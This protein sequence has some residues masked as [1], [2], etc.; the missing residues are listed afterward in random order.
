MFPDKRIQL[1]EV[2]P[3]S[4]EVTYYCKPTAAGNGDGLSWAN[5]C[6]FRTAVSRCSGTKLTTI[7]LGAGIH[8]TDNGSDATGTT[9]SA[10][11]VRVVGFGD[12]EEI[13]Q[14]SQLANQ[15]ASAT[16]VLKVTGN[17]FSLSHVAFDNSAELDKIVTHLNLQ[18]NYSTVRYCV[19]RQGTGDGACTGILI[20]NSS[21]SHTIE[22]NRFRRLEGNGINFGAASRFYINSN[23]F[24]SCAT[25]V[26]ASSAN[27]DSG[28]FRDNKYLNCTTALNI[29]T[30]VGKTWYFINAFYGNNTTNFTDVAS[31]GGTI[32]ILNPV[33]S[34]MAKNTYPTGAGITVAK[35]ANAWVWGAYVDI[36]PA[37]TLAKPFKLDMLNVQSWNAAQVFKI[38]LFY[39]AA[40]PGTISLGVHELLLGDP[41]AN[42]RVYAPL[43]LDVFVPAYATV[44]AKIMSS[45][46][47]SDN[48]VVTLGYD[49]L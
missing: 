47:S 38:E 46:A 31:Y 23:V 12:D 8:N 40:S 35:D 32:N 10:N 19:F 34:G 45:T 41:A 18:G 44:G 28:I 7:V 20:D 5:A 17:S 4:G 9:I 37:G 48:I 49:L 33:V 25:A 39:G 1:N 13:G 11:S 6:T 30:A 16:H 36:I 3:I 27:A 29:A 21:V 43:D 42:S 26:Y 2:A 24:W 22:G 15:A 14:A